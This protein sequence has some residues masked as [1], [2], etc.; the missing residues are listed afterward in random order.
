M[1]RSELMN[2]YFAMSGDSLTHLARRM[3]VH[4]GTLWTAIY[5]TE[6]PEIRTLQKLAKATDIPASCWLRTERG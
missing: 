4:Y 1:K 3:G 2:S 6:E 5:R